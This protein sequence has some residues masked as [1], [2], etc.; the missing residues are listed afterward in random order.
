M[1]L[2]NLVHQLGQ[3]L[4]NLSDLY[5]DAFIIESDFYFIIPAFKFN[6]VYIGRIL[7]CVLST[8]NAVNVDGIYQYSNKRWVF[9]L[10]IFP[11]RLSWQVRVV[12]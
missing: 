8:E 1:L 3:M 6:A 11:R 12:L 2:D 5:K 7:K 10:A 4:L 9:I